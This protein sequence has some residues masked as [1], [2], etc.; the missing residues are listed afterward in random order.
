MKM[1]KYLFLLF[2][3]LIE[4]S[5]F[6]QDFPS[7]DEEDDLQGDDPAAVPVNGKLLWLLVVGIAFAYY[8]FNTIS[9]AET[10]G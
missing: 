4:F 2:C 10:Q 1:P 6:A 7:E 5:A 9:R 8:K 3:L